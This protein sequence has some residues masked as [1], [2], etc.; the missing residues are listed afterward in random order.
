MTTEWW[1]QSIENSDIR[2]G[3]PHLAHLSVYQAQFADRDEVERIIDR[4]HQSLRAIELDVQSFGSPSA[5]FI[6]AD[7]TNPK[8]LQSLHQSM[9]DT[10]APHR[11]PLDP[12]IIRAL[13]ETRTPTQTRSLEKYGMALAGAGYRPHVTL[14]LVAHERE[15]DVLAGL[16]NQMRNSVRLRFNR[17][18]LIDCDPKNGSATTAHVEWLLQ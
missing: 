1:S 17:L 6:F 7:T 2:L 13:A 8:Q 12:A 15:Q 16:R 14:G 5:G 4:M 3:E 9:L 10:V 18:G 11:T